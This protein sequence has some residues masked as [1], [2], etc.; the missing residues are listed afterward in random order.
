MKPKPPLIFVSKLDRSRFLKQCNIGLW[1]DQGLDRVDNLFT[2][3]IDTCKHHMVRFALSARHVC[4]EKIKSN[5]SSYVA[6]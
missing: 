1:N 2:C 6:Y 3:L 4:F 5:I